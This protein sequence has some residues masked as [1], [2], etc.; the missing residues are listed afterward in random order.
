MALCKCR[1]GGGQLRVSSACKLRAARRLLDKQRGFYKRKT[2]TDD[3]IESPPSRVRR[4]WPRNGPDRSLAIADAAWLRMPVAVVLKPRLAEDRERSG[5]RYHARQ[6]GLAF[7]P[8]YDN[9][10]AGEGA[11][12]SKVSMSSF[13]ARLAGA[14]RRRYKNGEAKVRPEKG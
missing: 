5:Q 10:G 8:T 1:C 12:A 7:G 14:P 11:I 2:A 13:L 6:Q 4:I 3:W 9:R